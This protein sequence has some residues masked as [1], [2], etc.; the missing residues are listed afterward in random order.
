MVFGLEPAAALSISVALLTASPA[1]LEDATDSGGV[2][3][4]VNATVP[5]AGTGQRAVTLTADGKVVS[6]WRDC[7]STAPP[8]PSA[9][10]PIAM[11]RR[12]QQND[13]LANG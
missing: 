13:S 3:I 8:L 7:R 2:V 1:T 9:G 6:R 10:V 12:C 5:A 4:G 11:E